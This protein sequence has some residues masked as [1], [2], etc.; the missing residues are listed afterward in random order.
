M[1]LVHEP[2]ETGNPGLTGSAEPAP[3]WPGFKP[4]QVTKLEQESSDV[5]SL[6]FASTDGSRLPAALPGQFLVLRLRASSDGSPLLRNYSLSGAPGADHYRISVKREVD[7]AGSSFVHSRVH[8]GDILD[9][10]APRG[11][12]TLQTGD[13]PVVLASAGIGVTPVLAM[14]HALAA[15]GSQRQVWWLYGARNGHQHPFAAESRDL[16]KALSSARSHVVYSKP[17]A[18]DQPG[19]DY[20]SVGHLDVSLV[21]RLGVPRN[22][23]FYLCGPSSFLSSFSQ[24]LKTWGADRA[25]VRSEI[26]G[27]QGALT[28]GIQA[29]KPRPVHLPLGPPGVGPKVSFARSG[30]TAPWD[31]R[32]LSLLELAEACDVPTKWSCRTGVCHTCESALIDGMVAYRPDPL[33]L[34]AEGNV[35]LCCSQPLSDVEL[36][37]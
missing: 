27:S 32:Y 8:V 13:S 10:S 9:V 34:P 4:L 2:S 25:K 29:V 22:A 26:F 6:F 20:D 16:L 14:L 31:G 33:G 30:L 28:P 7:G 5:V 17:D 11:A 18:A 21:E 37:L 24:A 36:D 3:A 23:E 15:V 35:L 1:G 19:R 12:F